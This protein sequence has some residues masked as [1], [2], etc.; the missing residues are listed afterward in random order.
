MIAGIS[1]G[2]SYGGTVMGVRHWRCSATGEAEDCH[3]ARDD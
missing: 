3:D 2:I 1:V